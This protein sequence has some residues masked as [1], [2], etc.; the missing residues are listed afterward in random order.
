M[1][2]RIERRN[3]HENNFKVPFGKLLKKK[4]QGHYNNENLNISVSYSH[5]HVWIEKHANNK[6]DKQNPPT[7]NSDDALI[8][9]LQYL[10]RQVDNMSHIL[11]D[12]SYEI[13]CLRNVMNGSPPIVPPSTVKPEPKPFIRTF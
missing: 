6:V 10:E 13:Q 8:A 5:P 12:K 2:S 4:N 9:R 7:N 11:S 3:E 1:T